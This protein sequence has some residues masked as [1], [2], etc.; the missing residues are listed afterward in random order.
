MNT[1]RE[2]ALLDLLKGEE[3][4]GFAV[5]YFKEHPDILTE[6]LHASA[7][8]AGPRELDWED[9]ER[10]FNV[11]RFWPADNVW[12]DAQHLMG[13]EPKQGDEADALP[14]DESELGH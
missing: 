4:N 7:D 10:Q 12:P 9:I 11:Y 14:I 1:E 2:A 6:Y 3:T 8:T 5:W 13:R